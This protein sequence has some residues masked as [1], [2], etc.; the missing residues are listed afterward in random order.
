MCD[1]PDVSSPRPALP[2]RTLLRTAAWSAPAVAVV[3]AA[4]AHAVSTTAPSLAVTWRSDSFAGVYPLSTGPD[5]L[6]GDPP[7]DAAALALDIAVGGGPAS[8]RVQF[9]FPQIATLL[10]MTTPVTR[11][12]TTWTDHTTD[13]AGWTVTP[14]P[15]DFGSTGTSFLF[16]RTIT[17]GIAP[18]L[19]TWTEDFELRF[20]RLL[21]LSINVTASFAR[22]GGPVQLSRTLAVTGLASSPYL[23]AV[24][25][26]PGA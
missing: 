8:L 4:P 12:A 6:Q 17:D 25:A 21:P 23:T 2:R 7:A 5:S 22:P 15:S 26:A 10:S 18:L 1:P 3:A 19:T 9:T 13:L 11:G 14:P 16:Q 20:A 24:G